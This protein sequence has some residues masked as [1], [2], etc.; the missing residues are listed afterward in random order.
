[1]CRVSPTS[2]SPKRG[3]D[4]KARAQ[5]P[6][7]LID[8]DESDQQL[9]APQTPTE[10]RFAVWIGGSILASLGSFQQ[11]WMSKSEYDEIGASG[12]EAKCP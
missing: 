2:P 6:I 3:R 9:L 1:M 5:A 10:R 12:I 7:V 8:L 11:L 4:G